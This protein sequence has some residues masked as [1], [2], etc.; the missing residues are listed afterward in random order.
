MGSVRPMDQDFLNDVSEKGYKHWIT[1]EEHG[2]TGGLGSSILEWIS[3]N[4]SSKEI[5]LHRLGMPTKFVNKL[6]DQKYIREEFNLDSK[7]IVEFILNL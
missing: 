7:G 2:I 6:G 4:K 5:K 3:E 1:L